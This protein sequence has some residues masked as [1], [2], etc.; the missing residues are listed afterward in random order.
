MNGALDSR[1]I[2]RPLANRWPME[3]RWTSRHFQLLVNFWLT[4]LSSTTN[5][6]SGPYLMADRAA[7]DRPVLVA[8][9]ALLR[10]GRLD[11]AL[12]VLESELG[13]GC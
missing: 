11:A 13:G 10:A 12:L 8:I 4:V 9:D 6:T 3:K 1:G 7:S 2:G 5:S